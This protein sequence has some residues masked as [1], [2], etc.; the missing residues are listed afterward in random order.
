MNAIYKVIFK[1]GLLPAALFALLAAF[2][3]CDMKS[4]PGQDSSEYNPGQDST[5]ESMA[6]PYPDFEYATVKLLSL[7]RTI[8]DT[9]SN[10]MSEVLMPFSSVS[11]GFSFLDDQGVPLHKYYTERIPGSMRLKRCL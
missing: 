1:N 11:D 6:K 10:E 3:G 5:G 4:N 8:A 7:D 9:A 2:S